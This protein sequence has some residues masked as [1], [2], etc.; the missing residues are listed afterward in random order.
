MVEARRGNPTARR[1]R[2]VRWAKRVR[3]LGLA[4]QNA[5]EIARAGRLTAP[6]GFSFEVLHEERVYR[7]RRYEHTPDAGVTP[8]AEPLLLVPPLMVASEVYDISPDVSAVAFLA[9]Q[10]VDVWLVDFGA[11]EREEGGMSRTLDDHVRAV[12]DAIGRVR[13]A[14]GHD[15]HLA[16]YSQGGMFCYQAA[17]FRKSAGLASIVTMG[18]PV[19]LHRHLKVGEDISE[20]IVSGMRA[21]LSWP[22]ARIE[23]LP[24]MFTSTGFK[25]LSA[26]K[27]ALQLVDFVRN[28]HDRNALEKR[29]AKRLFLGGD[30]FVAWPGPAFRKFVDEVIVGN[31]MASGGIVIDGK[32]ITLADLSCPILYFVGTRD[33]MGRP[34]SVRGIRRAA[35]RVTKMYEV[36]LKAGHFGLVVGSTAL[37]VTW[38]GVVAWMRGEIPP[39]AID[40]RKQAPPEPAH[41]DDAEEDED[42]SPLDLAKELVEKTAKAA[43]DRVEEL[44]EDLG[45]YLDNARWQ[46]PRL[47]RLRNLEDDSRISLGKALAD[48][49]ARIGDKTFF[50]WRGR[51]FTY[52]EAN[53]RVDAIVRGLLACNVKVG[54]RVG[55]MMK[56]RPSHLSVVAAVNRLGAVGVLLSPDTGDDMLPKCLELG[57][58]EVL[59]VDPETAARVRAVTSIK[60]M[61]LGGVGEQGELPPGME[62]PARVI[63]PGVIDMETIDPEAVTPPA[64]YK[65]DA[66]RARDLAMVF[67]TSGKHEPPRAVRITNR[68]WAFSALG[69]AAAAT[70]TTRDTVYCCLPLHHPSG[71]LVAA[72]SALI[73][74]SRLALASR[75]AP[76]TFWDEVRRYGVSVVYYAGEMCRRLVDADPVLGEKNNPVRLF[77]GSGMRADVWRQLIDRFGPVGVLELYASTEANAV[78]ANAA[79]KKIGSV[80]R[81]L[82]GSPEVAI[83]SYNFAEHD[84]VHDG[85]G[86][87]VRARLDEPGMLVAKLSQRAGTDIAHIDPKRLIRDAFEPGDVWFVTGDVFKVDTVGDYWFV[88]RPSQMIHTRMGAVASTR[89]EDGLYECQCI[90]LCVA[91]PRPDPDDASAQMPVAAIQLHPGTALDLE[92][93]STAVQALPEYARPR[94]V[95]VVEQIPL[96][97]GFRPIKSRAFDSAGAQ[98]QWNPRTQRY[99][100]LRDTP[101]LRPVEA[102]R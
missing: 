53:R 84:L 74:G 3:R 91:A 9:R 101:V 59:I 34:G 72:H 6:Y 75:F 98:Y 66:G 77:A 73:G 14:T 2:Q 43:L 89:I 10:G 79:G 63:P 82:P 97:D 4:W 45:T 12:S 86:R 31:R 15:V 25:L 94:V 18:S 87:L 28:L 55:V 7:L 42:E 90:A 26:R 17:A 92:A 24:S 16:G 99:E 1:R 85:K 52:A 37:T 100:P 32:T 57:E 40:A 48:Q 61:V 78:L 51:A 30:G 11:P 29:E 56:S 22:L 19:D 83:A 102:V 60:V 64:W 46:L 33:E 8:I 81:P 93:L 62:R 76:E 88:D 36:M 27:E 44:S 70:L 67:V 41:A 39:T 65:P 96:T 47:H 54:T 68:R 58:V 95:R 69:A 49:A 38:P 5:L 21:A 80:G 20:R 71:T 13:E 35:P 23:G 50:L